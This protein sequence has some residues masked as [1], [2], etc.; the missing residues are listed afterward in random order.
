MR[1]PSAPNLST[2]R[3]DT[4][5]YLTAPALAI[6]IHSVNLA[7][8]A[9]PATAQRRVPPAWFDPAAPP[10]EPIPLAES[11]T[12]I[13]ITA[14]RRSTEKLASLQTPPPLSNSPNS[15]AL[16]RESTVDPT[17]VTTP[18]F[19]HPEPARSKE[20]GLH[21]SWQ[22]T[23]SG[24]AHPL[25]PLE[26][27]GDI[28]FDDAADCTRPLLP[29]S[30]PPLGI[31]QQPL[32]LHQ[33]SNRAA[34]MAAIDGPVDIATSRQ[35]ST[36]PRNQTSTLS[37]ALQ[38]AAAQ[39]I[40]TPTSAPRSGNDGRLSI[41]ARQDS[42]SHI[43]SYYGTG[44]RPIS[45][46]DRPRRESTTAG[47]LLNGMSWGGVSVGSWIRDDIVMAGTSPYAF[48]RSPSFHSSSYLPKMEANFMKD[49]NCCGLTLDSLHELLQHFEECHAAPSAT[50]QRSSISGQGG[51]NNGGRNSITS[52]GINPQQAE[53]QQMPHQ[54]NGFR[55][56][57]FQNQQFTSNG[58]NKSQLST[59]QDMDTL[60]DME[61]DDPQTPM[62][63]PQ[64]Q[65]SAQPPQFGQNNDRQPQLNINLANNVQNQAF[66]TSTPT[67]P[68]TNHPGFPLQNNPTVSSVN[69][70]TLG[71]AGQQRTP[72]SSVPG[73]PGEFDQDLGNYFGGLPM[74]MNAQMMQGNNMDFGNM[75]F[76]QN[77]YDCVDGTIDQPAKRLYSKQGGGLTPQ[78]LQFA[79]RQGKLGT[80]SELAKQLRASQLIMA[81]GGIFP[82]EEIKPF[83]CPVIGCEKA[84]K[85][86][87]GLKYHK[88]HGHQNQ[89]LKENAD[90]TFSIVDPET[91][92]PYPGTVGMEKEKPYRCETCG[93]RYKN[94]NGLKYHRAHSPPC[95]PELKLNAMNLL[96]AANLQGMNVNVAGAGMAGMGND[97]MF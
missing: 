44:A 6:R 3:R 9:R 36:S 87:N 35:N 25:D 50:M 47:S 2:A 1:E 97:G 76:N 19:A 27:D 55:P 38:G 60:E 37:A 86:Q 40:A 61:M 80:D 66:R 17:P 31:G 53:N 29:A 14:V 65:F 95:N 85:N 73:T 48:G 46:K 79:L 16:D 22:S 84:Y 57:Q 32:S 30:P 94:L 58:F 93:K 77:G 75:G 90:G 63:V 18:V 11:G 72:D 68:N 21:F 62:G 33:A 24:H 54:Q 28:L 45:V 51:F 43:G 15:S 71:A 70:P 10:T 89:Q 88:Q 26:L 91:S 92:V 64:Q 20:K 41:G 56:Q 59:V 52:G 42:I 5:P 13:D 4:H 78:Q 39:P 69:T 7:W 96:S 83:K 49:F 8:L 23:P 34:Q 74:G 12:P 67:T 81:N 82:G